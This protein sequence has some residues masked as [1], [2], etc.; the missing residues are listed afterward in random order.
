[1]EEAELKRKREESDRALRAEL[2]RLMALKPT[3]EQEAGEHVGW[4][5]S[6]LHADHWFRLF[7]LEPTKAAMLLCNFNPHNVTLEQAQRTTT[8]FIAPR[9]LVCLAERFND[10]AKNAPQPRSL[11]QWLQT[12]RALK[13]RYDPWIEQYVEA[14]GLDVDGATA[15][16]PTPAVSEPVPKV[17]DNPRLRIQ[18][19]ACAEWTRWLARGAQPTVHSIAPVL[20][21]WCLDNEVRTKGGVNPAAGTIRN[22]IIGAGHW[23]PPNMTREQA[24]AQVEQV[25][26]GSVAQVA[27]ERT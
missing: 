2:D 1:M 25:A 7:D 26:Q 16:A 5:N 21:R 18:A 12:A 11:L 15:A 23:I 19:E 27:Q 14:T 17:H 10:L 4:S 8:D 20:A 22:T 6:L 13:L 3:P 24:K 9:D